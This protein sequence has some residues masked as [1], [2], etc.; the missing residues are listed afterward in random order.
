VAQLRLSTPSDDERLS[1]RCNQEK[2]VIAKDNVALDSGPPAVDVVAA[3]WSL[4]PS[5]DELDVHRVQ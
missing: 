1:D 4:G 2:S 3:M 5:D